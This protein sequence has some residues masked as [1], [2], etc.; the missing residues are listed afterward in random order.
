MLLVMGAIDLH[1]VGTRENE[2]SLTTGMAPEDS[3]QDQYW[4]EAHHGERKER[5]VCRS[6]ASK[7]R[8][9]SETDI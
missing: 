2:S 1:S 8:A 6:C 3:V 4:Y 9:E 7:R 5:G